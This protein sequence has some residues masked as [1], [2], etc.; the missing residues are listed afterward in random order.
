[1]VRPAAFARALAAF[2]AA[3]AALAAIFVLAPAPALAADLP[4]A[5]GMY[6]TSGPA[7]AM[8]DSK[9][10][11]TVRGPI[12]EVVVT[13]RFTN[14]AD[15][16]TEAT[17]VFPLPADAA[18][19]AMSIRT[20]TRTIHG[21]IE[22]RDDAQRR[23]EAAI[24]E[25]VGAGLLDQERP[26][27]FTQTVAA[28]PA[29]GTVDVTLRYDTLA[30]YAGGTW[31]LVLPM[32]VAPRYV[33]GAATSRPTTGTGRAPDTDRAPDAS[34]ITPPGAP[35][36]GGATSVV[37][38]FTDK[39]LDPTSPT[40]ELRAAGAEATFTDPKTDHDAIVRWRAPAPAAGWVE[41]GPDGGYAAV[42]VEAPPAAPRKGALRL[43][44][45][46]DRSAASLGDADAV[47]R[48]FVRA[49]LGGLGPADRVALA[50]SDQLGWSTPADAARA[51]DDAWPRA[52]GA[53]DLTRVLAVA[54]P[55]GAPVILVSGGLVA[56]DAA[57]LAAAKKLG[58]PVHIVGVG[59]AP[60]RGLLGGVATAAGGTARF[61][62][63]GDDLA[64][65][66]KAVV[67]D[68]AAPPAL[69]S[70]TWG[71]LVAS[72]V[73]PGI[74]PRLGAGQA[75]IVLARVRGAQPANA[76]A[77]GELFAIEAL[78]APRAVDGATS[79]MGPLARRW[80][81]AR[82]EELIAARATPP[83]ITAHALR[84]GLV[85]PH[86]SLVAIG[87]EV[88]VAGGVR[89]SIP[90]PVSVPAGMRWQ[91][92]KKQ[93]TVDPTVVAPTSP[94]VKEPAPDVTAKVP[95]QRPGDL[96]LDKRD[97]GAGA[98]QEDDPAPRG[99]KGRK[100][101][102]KADEEEK[103]SKKKAAVKDEPRR[104]VR[105]SPAAQAGP[106][107]VTTTAAQKPT[108]G[109]PA[110]ALPPAPP[111][112]APP[113]E[114]Q[115][116]GDFADDTAASARAPRD[117][118]ALGASAGTDE[119]DYELVEITG[120]AAPRRLRITA[121]LGGGVAL[122][123]DRGAPLFSLAMR[124][125]R[126][127]GRRTLAGAG[128]S[129][130]IAGGA[131]D[132]GADVQGQILVTFARGLGRHLEVGAGL[133]LHLGAGTGPAASLS[134]RYHLPPKPRVAA[135]LRYDGALLIEADTRTGQHAATFG[136]EYGF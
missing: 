93:T 54:R 18:V 64:A 20:G 91:A 37:V 21:A 92:V 26:D 127:L 51:L 114:P 108:P 66:A 8:V 31:E 100:N 131:G 4:R 30:R 80:A 65:A 49:L 50:G 122:T 14:R 95:A 44:L 48:S 130:W 42:V 73:V 102:R 135:M 62:A 76:R 11:V 16:P 89:R 123:T 43:L 63:A 52:A 69:L 40:H 56:D 106:R 15:H 57:A 105:K 25:G 27:V 111:P 46:L 94:P 61:L 97:A 75:V 53:F 41:A 128:A 67:A 45:V 72:D 5:I 79:A 83:A 28:I 124:V 38:R 60:A 136:L 117:S 104:P 17:Y 99:K 98:D 35:G 22:R 132:R 59:P 121:A 126:G 103:P 82:L 13:Q 81:R 68:A 129:L 101:D 34:R 33:P 85:S 86:T 116:E 87:D 32:V 10:E 6:P 109:K 2:A 119:S 19:T 39:I 96:A 90:V 47:A 118:V 125:E 58:V 23:Y 113:P 107:A 84:Y 115:A 133:G 70:V 110:A 71:T 74:L 12:A 88:V 55:E 7:L 1:M 9:I 78:P 36:A 77:R 3:L 134:L 120:M 24:R 112:A 29:R